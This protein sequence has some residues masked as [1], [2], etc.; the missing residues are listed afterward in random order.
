LEPHLPPGQGRTCTPTTPTTTYH[1][2]PTTTISFWTHTCLY[3]TYH[4]P[5]CLPPGLPLDR[6]PCLGLGSS[7]HH[8][9]HALVHHLYHRPF[10][11]CLAYLTF[12]APVDAFAFWLILPP[13]L[14]CA[15]PGT[16]Q[17]SIA[18]TYARAGQTRCRHCCQRLPDC[19]YLLKL[20]RTRTAQL[21]PAC[22]VTAGARACVAAGFC[23]HAYLAIA[24]YCRLMLRRLAACGALPNAAALY[25]CGSACRRLVCHAGSVARRPYAGSGP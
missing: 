17:R 16:A 14:R 8:L 19:R 7:Y 24:A 3:I 13:R 18:A 6:L 11:A 2:F 5:T 21:L 20:P 25:A 15:P 23:E 4:H 9:P 22:A 12:C 10:S 1:S